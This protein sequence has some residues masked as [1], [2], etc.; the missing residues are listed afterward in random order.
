MKKPASWKTGPDA[1]TSKPDVVEDPE[2]EVA[3][4]DPEVDAFE[5][6]P[7]VASADL[8]KTVPKIKKFKGLLKSKLLP[9]WLKG[10][11]KRTESLS[12]GR[13]E[14][15]RKL[16]NAAIDRCPTG[17]LMLQPDK[18]ELKDTNIDTV[19]RVPIRTP[20]KLEFRRR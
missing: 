13:Y 15:Q 9:E 8:R 1:E 6:Q 10:E 17:K 20:P 7:N 12:S 14:A 2:E 18:V 3:E 4:T 5:V 19:N 16:V 11:W